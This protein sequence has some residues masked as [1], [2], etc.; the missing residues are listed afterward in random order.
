MLKRHLI[1]F[2]KEE[3]LKINEVAS[4]TYCAY[5]K[6]N[7]KSYPGPKPGSYMPRKPK[8]APSLEEIIKKYEAL[9]EYEKLSK[10][11]MVSYYK[12]ELLKIKKGEHSSLD[13]GDRRCLQHLGL[14]TKYGLTPLCKELLEK[15]LM[16]RI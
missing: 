14:L 4:E 8:V 6:L 9:D 5:R 13:K 11:N 12:N 7:N 2:H 10:T 1:R 15:E 16:K 3:E